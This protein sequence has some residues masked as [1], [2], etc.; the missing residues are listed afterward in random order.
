MDAVAVGAAPPPSPAPPPPEFWFVPAGE[1]SSA[2]PDPSS[3]ASEGIWT[4]RR[5][6]VAADFMDELVFVREGGMMP[7]EDMVLERPG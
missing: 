6:R 1:D 3:E 7:S 4:L 2:V 5:G